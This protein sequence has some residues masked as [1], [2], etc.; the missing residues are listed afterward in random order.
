M[1]PPL[2]VGRVPVQDEPALRRDEVADLSEHRVR[3]G[4]RDQAH[5]N[6]GGGGGRHDRPR[7][8]PHPGARQAA[9]VERG[10]L[11]RLLQGTADPVGLREP[12]GSHHGREVVGNRRQRAPFLGG[13]L[14][15]VVE[16]RDHDPAALVL[17]RGD[18]LRQPDRRVRRP[19]A[20]VAAVQRNARP[21]HDEFEGQDAAGAETDRGPAALVERAVEDEHR[22]GGEPAPVAGDRGDEVRGPGLL[23]A[24]EDQLEVAGDRDVRCVERVEGAEQGD[25]RRGVVGDG[26]G[27]DA[28][29]GAEHLAGVQVEEPGA[30]GQTAVA[31]DR[32]E[33]VLLFPPGRVHRLAVVVE[34]DEQRAVGAGGRPLAEDERVAFGL[35]E[36]GHETA[37]LEGGP[38]EL[39]LAP[40]VRGVGRDRRNGDRLHELGHELPLRAVHVFL[41]GGAQ[42]LRGRRSGERRTGGEED[43]P[44]EAWQP[45]RGRSSLPAGASTSSSPNSRSSG[46]SRSNS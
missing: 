13:E 44:G 6:G 33:R 7:L 42:I 2:G 25:D 5:V 15:A 23:L 9:H 16:P 35:E 30:V 1:F 28:V 26:A 36:F 27:V 10:E 8:A 21:V 31:E 4:L 41:D 18:E 34:V 20:V 12:K 46:R 37:P 3:R 38:Q 45:H 43:C 11:D 32:P 17:H 24:V 22:V 40:D 14:D 29:V 39:R 19:V